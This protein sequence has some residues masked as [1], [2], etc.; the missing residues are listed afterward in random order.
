MLQKLAERR[1]R[2]LIPEL[3]AFPG[4]KTDPGMLKGITSKLKEAK[5]DNPDKALVSKN[6]FQ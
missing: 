5:T 3:D 2:E 4:S 1:S 6:D